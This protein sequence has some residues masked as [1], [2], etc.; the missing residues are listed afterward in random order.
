MLLDRPHQQY[1]ALF[2]Q[3]F[4]LIVF[5]YDLGKKGNDL[6]YTIKRNLSDE[7]ASVTKGLFYSESIC[8]TDN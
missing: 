4:N 2:M 1:V 3:L 8:T 6:N 7:I 5:L